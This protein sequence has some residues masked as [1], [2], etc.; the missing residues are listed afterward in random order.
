[1]SFNL[2]SQRLRSGKDE[3]GVRTLSRCSVSSP[4]TT[5]FALW[6]EEKK[7]IAVI[8]LVSKTV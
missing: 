1:M 4:P 8:H 3:F 7:W 5:A 2:F 6:M